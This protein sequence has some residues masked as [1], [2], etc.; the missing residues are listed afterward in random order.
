MSTRPRY[1]QQEFRSGRCLKP[2]IEPDSIAQARVR[3]TETDLAVLPVLGGGV[4]EAATA[5]KNSMFFEIEPASGR[6][7]INPDFVP[8]AL[9]YKERAAFNQD[10]LLAAL[11]AGPYAHQYIYFDLGARLGRLLTHRPDE[12]EP[13][14][15]M[16]WDALIQHY[17]DELKPAIKVTPEDWDRIAVEWQQFTHKNHSVQPPP[18]ALNRTN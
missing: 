16:L 5:R 11:P 1:T 15:Q 17:G 2:G 6:L 9:A 18:A 7:Q 3:F 10:R 13:D 12:T 4:D 8:L 14:Q